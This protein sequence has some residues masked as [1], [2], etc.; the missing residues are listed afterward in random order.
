MPGL[1]EWLETPLGQ[2]LLQREIAYFDQTVGDIFGFNALQLGLVRYDL[3]SKNRMPFRFCAGPACPG[4][5]GG[6]VKVVTDLQ[7]LPFATQS[8]DLLLLPHVL[9][10]SENPH[11][12]LREAARILMPE[13]RIVISGFN[14][15]S[16]WGLPRLLG[17]HR[18]EYPWRGNFI[19]LRRIKDWLALLG[20]EVEGGRM[21]CYVPPVSGEKWLN[22]FRFL[23]AAGDRWWALAGGV[24]F[25]QAKKRV[26]GMRLIT[27]AWTE[28]A[29]AKKALKP[30]AQKTL[31]EKTPK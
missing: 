9:E 10:F 21:C 11:Q 6:V 12:I 26:H 14:P 30:L 16:L 3:L 7:H 20:F 19:S 23:E 31:T 24:Y 25:L 17:R 15:F 8:I 4:V 22:R 27:P 28:R 5:A 29:A 13:G 18:Q 2:Y 1:H